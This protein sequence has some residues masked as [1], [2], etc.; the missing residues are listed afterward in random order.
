MG[1][2]G[3]R[4]R[5]H[6]QN[7]TLLRELLLR[8]IPWDTGHSVLPRVANLSVCQ[9]SAQSLPGS[10]LRSN[11]T[12]GAVAPFVAALVVADGLFA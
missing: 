8:G 10:A 3:P 4:L 2:K 5:T 9:T 1:I 7:M 12:R 6:N 11:V